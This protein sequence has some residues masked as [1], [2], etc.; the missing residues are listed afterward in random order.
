MDITVGWFTNKYQFLLI[1]YAAINGSDTHKY[2]EN[3]AY[4]ESR[5]YE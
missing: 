3:M 5:Y 4:I 2:F 1:R